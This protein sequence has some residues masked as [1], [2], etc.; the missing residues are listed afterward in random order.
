ML[1]KRTLPVNLSLATKCILA[2]KTSRGV[3]ASTILCKTLKVSLFQLLTVVRLHHLSNLL[4]NSRSRKRKVRSASHS[5]SFKLSKKAKMKRI[6]IG[7]LPRVV[8]LRRLK[9]FPKRQRSSQTPK[10]RCLQGPS[11]FRPSRA[12]LRVTSLMCKT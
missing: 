10:P 9:L 2:T 7:T 3:E 6:A 1:D 5:R 12:S 8:L 11:L 4:A